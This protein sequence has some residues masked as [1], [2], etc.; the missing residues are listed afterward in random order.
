MK[1]DAPISND[2]LLR[3]LY[4]LESFPE[5]EAKLYGM[6]RSAIRLLN[7]VENSNKL[8]EIERRKKW[9]KGAFWAY[10]KF[11]RVLKKNDTLW[12][13]DFMS[14]SEIILG[15]RLVPSQ[16]EGQIGPSCILRSLFDVEG[17]RKILIKKVPPITLLSV[18]TDLKQPSFELPTEAHERFI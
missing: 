1:K 10:A 4:P 3:R 11:V 14:E 12:N 17:R 2:E 7:E 13:L 5:K 8:E 9:V 6:V 16:C 15:E 18:V